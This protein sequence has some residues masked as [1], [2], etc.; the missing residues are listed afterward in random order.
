MGNNVTGATSN[1]GGA[2]NYS[3]EQ[4]LFISSQPSKTQS[5]YASE[6]SHLPHI[7][8]NDTS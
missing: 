5:K 3:N 4:L 8:Q 2:S 1:N 6:Y 7:R